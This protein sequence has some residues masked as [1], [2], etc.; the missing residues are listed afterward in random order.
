MLFISACF[1]TGE[2]PPRIQSLKAQYESFAQ[3]KKTYSLIMKNA[4]ER[5]QKAEEQ[6]QAGA[7]QAAAS[8]NVLHE[9]NRNLQQDIR[10]M[11][12]EQ[13]RLQSQVETLVQQN[14]ELIRILTIPR[15]T[16]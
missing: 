6:P 2:F 7:A 10:E 3:L 1:L 14:R 5:L 13:L 8:D 9:S 15:S 11:R 4:T 16:N 12:V